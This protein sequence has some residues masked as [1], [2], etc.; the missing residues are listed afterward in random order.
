MGVVAYNNNCLQWTVTQAFHSGLI[1]SVYLFWC[2]AL[3][4]TSHTFSF[5]KPQLFLSILLFFGWL[6][7]DFHHCVV[8]MCSC[9]C[10]SGP[11]CKGEQQVWEHKCQWTC[12][13]TRGC[14]TMRPH[15]VNPP[16]GKTAVCGMYD[17][18]RQLS[19][20]RESRVSYLKKKLINEIQF[21]VLRK[22]QVFLRV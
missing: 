19:F 5:P 15:P 10:A 13:H 2:S 11:G 3:L 7:L 17:F 22:N 16:E 14:T 9:L 18:K 4:L 12:S 20:T 6:C 21:L 1:C 8:L